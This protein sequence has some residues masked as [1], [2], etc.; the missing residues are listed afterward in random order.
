[1]PRFV[2]MPN[3]ELAGVGKGGKKNCIGRL[4]REA[5]YCPCVVYFMTYKYC[6][7]GFNVPGCGY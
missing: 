3:G 6:V 5:H 1:M 4:N 2:V 7:Q